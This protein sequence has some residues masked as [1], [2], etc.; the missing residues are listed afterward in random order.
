MGILYQLQNVQHTLPLFI[1][2]ERFSVNFRNT[3]Y[4]EI[5]KG[6]TKEISRE[7]V[8]YV[9]TECNL[10][11]RQYEMELDFARTLSL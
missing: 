6:I 2:R 3:V 5:S 4:E 9:K 10:L 1:S 7:V 8:K 11:L